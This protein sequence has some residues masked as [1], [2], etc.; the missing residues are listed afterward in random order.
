MHQVLVIAFGGDDHDAERQRNQKKCGKRGIFF[1]RRCPGDQAGAD[2]DEK[3]HNQPATGHREN[4][5]ARNQETDGC[6]GQDGV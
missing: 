5:Q 2:G 3:A 4:A 6:P 1:Y